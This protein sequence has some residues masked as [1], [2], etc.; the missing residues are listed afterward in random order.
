[1]AQP[2]STA[3]GP[4][5]GV[6]FS[7]IGE[8]FELVKNNWQA[9]CIFSLVMIIATYAISMV[10]T[11]PMSMAQA[12]APAAATS[13]AAMA[14]AMASLPLNLLSNFVNNVVM[15][16]LMAGVANMTLKAI[17][18]EKPELADGF[19]VFNMFGPIAL[20]GI[21]Y[22]I[23]TTLGLLAC[24]IG[25][26]IVIGLLLPVYP[27]I[28]HERLGVMDAFKR[29]LELM[30][31]HWLMAGVFSFVIG[32]VAGL[33]VLACCVGVF[34]TVPLAYACNTLIYRDV[35]GLTFGPNSATVYPRAGGGAMP[36]YS[37]PANGD[38]PM[39][40]G[41]MGGSGDVPPSDPEQP[42]G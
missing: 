10:I 6:E 3:Q 20:A 35:S 38:S 1:M 36:G 31:P 19:A 23:C 2:Y 15:A 27:I 39:D 11:L 16:F 21:L 32:L 18:G 5:G 22:A 42:Q 4:R 28:I 41:S 13:E 25:T 7:V 26:F 30:G 34:F 12:M 8:A 40:P 9:Y 17:R 37:G 24:C 29:S 33:G 14:Q